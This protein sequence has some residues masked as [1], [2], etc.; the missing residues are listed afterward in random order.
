MPRFDSSSSSS[1]HSK[2][3]IIAARILFKHLKRQNYWIIKLDINLLGPNLS[4]VQGKNWKRGVQ[5][6]FSAHFLV[7]QKF[8]SISPHLRILLN[9]LVLVR[10]AKCI[11]F[12][13]R[14][15]DLP[16]F[17]L[18]TALFT[19]CCRPRNCRR[20]WRRWRRRHRVASSWRR[21]FWQIVGTSRQRKESGENCS[22]KSRPGRVAELLEHPFNSSCKQ[23]GSHLSIRSDISTSW[24][25]VFYFSNNN[26]NIKICVIMYWL[27]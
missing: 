27:T 18:K 3:P 9:W 12:Q 22:K 20:R 14:C 13:N 1:Q 10:Y 26:N 8:N 21:E 24:R 17:D 16:G 5:F 19:F 15:I 11:N 4:K 23:T 25:V 7:K 2:Y 6:N